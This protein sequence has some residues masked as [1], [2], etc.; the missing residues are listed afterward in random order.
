MEITVNGKPFEHLIYHY[1]LA[2][3]GWQYAQIVQGGEER[4]GRRQLPT[5]APINS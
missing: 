4:R 3:S 1:R 5:A 2:Y